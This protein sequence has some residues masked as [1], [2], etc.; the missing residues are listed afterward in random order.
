M[1]LSS[2]RPAGPLKAP[3]LLRLSSI[4]LLACLVSGPVVPMAGAETPGAPRV[5]EGAVI[6]GLVRSGDGEPVVGAAVSVEGGGP[7]VRTDGQGLFRLESFPAGTFEV[8]IVAPG[9]AEETRV[10][11]AEGMGRSE[12][13]GP[14]EIVLQRTV[15]EE[16]SVTASYSLLRSTPTSSAVLTREEVQLAPHFGDDLFRAISILPGT[17]T[18]DLSAGFTVRGG[19]QDETLVLLD[20]VELFE[21]FH[22]KEVEGGFFSILDPEVTGAV[23]LISSGFGAEYGNRQTAVL[24]MTSADWDPRHRVRLAASFSN[25]SAASG[26]A[27]RGGEVDWL[28]SLRRGYL[29]ILLELAGEDDAPGISYWDAFGKLRYRGSER[30]SWNF[31]VLA[32]GDTFDYTEADDDEPFVGDATYGNTTAWLRH[33]AFLDGR[34]LLDSALSWTRLDSERRYTDVVRVGGVRE[35]RGVDH[36]PEFDVAT[37][38]QDLAADLG[39]R[40]WLKAGWSA[41]RFDGQYRYR[42]AASG[43]VPVQND[44]RF[45]DPNGQLAVAFDRRQER[46][47]LYLSDRI[48]LGSRLTLEVGAR[49]DR[50]DHFEETQVSPRLNGVVDLERY[51]VLRFAAGRFRQAH[52]LTELSVADGDLTLY[53]DEVSDL[54]QVGYQNSFGAGRWTVRA[55]AYRREI[56]SPRPRYQSVFDTFTPFPELE[57]DRVRLEPESA[58]TEGL[59]LF[60]SYRGGNRWSGWVSY[61]TSTASDVVDGREIPRFFD[62][63]HAVTLNLQYQPDDVWSLNG[64]WIYHTG[65]P[66]TDVGLGF[67]PEIGFFLGVGPLYA[68]NLPD[69]HRLDLRIS[70]RID[71]RRG[72]L[73]AFLDL[74]NAYDRKNIRGFDFDPGEIVLDSDNRV[75]LEPN[76]SFGVLPSLGISWTF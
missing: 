8:R 36:D 53:P 62:Q 73:M 9:F 25:L 52:R 23:E 24:D 64:V 26:G 67:D 5:I 34:W 27:L 40:H 68:S 37:W 54:F 28:A 76:D 63:S 4:P 2:L 3:R 18:S 75:F 32:A 22:L 13:S 42:R 38:R 33:Q 50:D 12:A 48:R 58:E 21:P 46:Y 61:V 14:L 1:R 70:R 56:D 30:S 60:L 74:Q 11:D 55:E 57:S 43:I 69:Y 47:G 72:R 7:V 65:W 20:G 15:E 17:A 29:D 66:S 59:E 51:G 35:V 71:T 16:I 44:P 41:R 19:F 45:M 39:D 49:A 31:N 6:E 10:L